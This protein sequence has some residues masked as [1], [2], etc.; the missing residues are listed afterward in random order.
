MVVRFLPDPLHFVDNA[1][2]SSS[3]NPLEGY[4]SRVKENYRRHRAL[5]RKYREHYFQ[6]Y[7]FLHLDEK[8]QHFLNIIPIARS[9]ATKFHFLNPA[10]KRNPR[11][12]QSVF[13]LSRSRNFDWWGGRASS[14]FNVAPNCD[15][16]D[17]GAPL[18]RGD[19]TDCVMGASPRALNLGKCFFL[20]LSFLKKVAIMD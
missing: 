8:Q 5:P 14:A 17:D 11:A 1:G 19:I 13:N 15:R 20:P 18:C 10:G 3:T 7:F 12:G 9:A 6:R 2:I 4:F 16:P